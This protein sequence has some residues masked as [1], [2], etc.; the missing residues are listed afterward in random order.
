M[1]VDDILNV[2]IKPMHVLIGFVAIQ[3]IYKMAFMSA[4]VNLVKGLYK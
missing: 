2:E 1:R 3:F 4:Y